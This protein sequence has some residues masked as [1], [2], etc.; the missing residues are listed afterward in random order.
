MNPCDNRRAA[1]LKVVVD[2]ARTSER[3][4]EDGG[5]SRLYEGL[6]GGAGGSTGG[7]NVVHKEDVLAADG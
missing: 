6:R 3:R 7:K 4:D 5:R 1:G 2:A